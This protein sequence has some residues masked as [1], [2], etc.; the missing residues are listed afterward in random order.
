MVNARI[1]TVSGGH[2]PVA[3][4]S[5]SFYIDTETWF[6]YIRRISPFANDA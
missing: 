6:A 5:L 2:L 1:T 3:N 4:T